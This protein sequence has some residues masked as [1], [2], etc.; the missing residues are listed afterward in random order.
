MAAATESYTELQAR[1]EDLLRGE[2][3]YYFICCV[4]IVVHHTVVLTHT[5]NY[6]NPYYRDMTLVIVYPQLWMITYNVPKHLL[7][8]LQ[9]EL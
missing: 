2:V 6:Y 9:K 5:I 1:Y 4:V 7:L 3:C 8:Q